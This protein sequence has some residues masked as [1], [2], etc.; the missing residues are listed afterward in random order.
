MIL[1]S[2]YTETLTKKSFQ[3]AIE[4]EHWRYKLEKIKIVSTWKKMITLV[5]EF[6][7]SDR[8]SRA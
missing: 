7:N 5:I 8:N 3:Y 2:N 1:I 6:L 4:K